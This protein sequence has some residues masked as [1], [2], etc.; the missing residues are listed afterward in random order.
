MAAG[1]SGSQRATSPSSGLRTD[2]QS[3]G[4]FDNDE[5]TMN[6]ILA[7]ILGGKPKHPFT[8]DVLKQY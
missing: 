2:S 6:D 4:G 1:R 7:T 3:H 5:T 8:P